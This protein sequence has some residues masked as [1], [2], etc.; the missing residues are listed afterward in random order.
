MI[1]ELVFLENN[2][3]LHPR[4]FESSGD[5]MPIPNVDD[6]VQFGEQVYSIVSRSFHYREPEHDAPIRQ[7]SV[8]VTVNCRRA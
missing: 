3:P 5:T 1:V 4:P 6:R 8:R 7:P 2:E